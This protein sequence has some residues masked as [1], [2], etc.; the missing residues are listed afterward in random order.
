MGQRQTTKPD[1]SVYCVVQTS[2]L[3]YFEILEYFTTVWQIVYVNQELCLKHFNVYSKIKS[4]CRTL[5]L[6]LWLWSMTLWEPWWPVAT[7]IITVKLA[8]LWV[9][10]VYPV[11]QSVNVSN[12]WLTCQLAEHMDTNVGTKSN[13]T[14]WAVFQGEKIIVPGNWTTFALCKTDHWV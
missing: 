9:S 12:C 14:K 7:M 11:Y 4:R 3:K 2:D 8:S 6:T 10:P 13:R 1:F 5:T